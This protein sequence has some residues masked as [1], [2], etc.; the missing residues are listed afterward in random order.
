MEQEKIEFIK[1]KVDSVILSLKDKIDDLKVT[2]TEREEIL[3]DVNELEDVVD[4]LTIE[5]TKNIKKEE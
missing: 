3:F 2:T 1:N 5:L 4:Y